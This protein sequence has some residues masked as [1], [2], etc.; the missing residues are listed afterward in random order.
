MTVE[1]IICQKVEEALKPELLQ[2]ENESHMHA[3]PRTD[4]HFKLVVVSDQFKGLGK[5]RRHQHVYRLLATELQGSIHALALHLYTP[6]EW[7]NSTVPD[8]PLC[9]KNK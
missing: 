5:V 7:K 1:S 2:L 6:E 8:S 9:S 4:S 3:G